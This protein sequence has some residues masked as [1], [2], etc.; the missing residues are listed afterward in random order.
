MLLPALVVM[1]RYNAWC[2]HPK[3]RGGARFRE[4]VREGDR[5]SG[6]CGERDMLEL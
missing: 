1:I 4:R 3:I 5:W 2:A 6:V